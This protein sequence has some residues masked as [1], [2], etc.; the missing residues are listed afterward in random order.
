VPWQQE[1]REKD[2]LRT[3]REAVRVAPNDSDHH[4]VAALIRGN[5]E[6]AKEALP[7]CG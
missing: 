3:I 5:V 4:A 6:S 2:A 1:G 7:S